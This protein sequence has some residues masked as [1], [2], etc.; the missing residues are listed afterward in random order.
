MQV[1]ASDLRD[2]ECLTSLAAMSLEESR[3]KPSTIESHVGVVELRGKKKGVRKTLTM[4]DI[5]ATLA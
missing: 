5:V 4:R 2:D 3:R 1:R